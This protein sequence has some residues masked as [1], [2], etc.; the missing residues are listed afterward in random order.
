MTVDRPG[1]RATGLRTAGLAVVAGTAAL[2]V[3]LAG[4]FGDSQRPAPSPLIGR[5]VP[6][7]VVPPLRG[8]GDIDLDRLSD[9]RVV[10]V[11]FFASWC[12]SCRV[13][14]ADLLATAAAYR[15]RDVVF[16]GLAYQDRLED[17]RRFLDEVGWSELTL[18]GQDPGSRA[19]IAFGVRGIPETFVIKSDGIVAA[20]LIGP[21]D[22]LTLSTV[23][24]EVLRGS[25]P[26]EQVLGD[27]QESPGG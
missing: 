12:A 20:R 17:A 1:R 9:G 18:Y 23:I 5:P 25:I 16:V 2:A 4:R 7:V 14:H 22:A 10:V 8:E 26:G 11:N 27:Q 13:E 6:V 19:A 24:E 21:V 3:V 15:D